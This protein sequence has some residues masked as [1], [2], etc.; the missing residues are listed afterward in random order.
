MLNYTKKSALSTNPRIYD[1]ENITH[2]KL[3]NT[4]NKSMG[5]ET[6]NNSFHEKEN[7]SEP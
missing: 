3:E 5:L 2:F 7:G 4:E 6:A 1:E